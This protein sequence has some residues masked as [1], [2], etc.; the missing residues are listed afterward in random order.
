[1]ILDPAT[2]ALL[3]IDL[4]A[5]FCSDRGSVA[6]QGRDVAPC[7]AAA[8]VCDG[9]AGLARAHGVPVI[10]TRLVF[11]PDYGDGGVLI[12]DLRP[13]L[14]TVGALRAGTPDAALVIEADAADY[15]IDKSRYSAFYA[16]GLEA[17]LRSLDIECLIV[18]GVT[19]SMCV[20]TTVRDASQRDYRTFVVREACGDFDGA[21]HEASLSALAF[22]FARVISRDQAADAIRDGRQD[23]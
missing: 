12:R 1:M 20:D 23:F 8:G 17:V 11:R 19:T 7:R 2:A 10:W 22:G 15:V 16:T 4:Q 5:A 21:R 18:G 13:G 9:L 14:K 6:R 3:A